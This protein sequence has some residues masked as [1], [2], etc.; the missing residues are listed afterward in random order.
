MDASITEFHFSQAMGSLLKRCDENG[1]ELSGIFLD[2]YE[3][4]TQT[5]T[6]RFR[7][8]F[9][10]RTGYDMT[11]FLPALTGRVVGSEMRSECFLWDYRKVISDLIAENFYGKL[12]QL[13]HAR[14]LRFYGEPYGGYF[15]DMRASEEQDVLVGEFWNGYITNNT[16][17]TASAAHISGRNIVG[18]EAF[19]AQ[20]H[21]GSFANTPF[22]LKR[23]GDLT[24]TEG[25]TWNILHSYVH[26]PY[27]ELKPGFTL[28]RYGT[29]FGRH[30]TWWPGCSALPCWASW[31]RTATTVC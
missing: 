11:P 3:A 9:R 14:G 2:S 4:A 1:Y 22:S 17:F 18:A 21:Y 5:W 28:S 16:R 23:W 15:D 24:F 12:R 8:E 25:L 27:E 7:E 10:K 13:I 19:T 30:N 31:W 20:P 29:H 26:Q 6:Q